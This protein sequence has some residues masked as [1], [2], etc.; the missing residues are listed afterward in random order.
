MLPDVKA[1]RN[2]ASRDPGVSRRISR[3]PSPTLT[4]ASCPQ[5]ESAPKCDLASLTTAASISQTVSV[6]PGLA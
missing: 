1:S 6:S 5:L 3:R 4:S 2:S